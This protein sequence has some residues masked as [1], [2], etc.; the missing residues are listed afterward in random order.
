MT[1]IIEENFSCISM[2]KSE[3]SY[4]QNWLTVKNI[5]VEILDRGSLRQKDAYTPHDYRNHCVNI[6]NIISNIILKENFSGLNTEELFIL[7]VAVLL[8]DV[9]MALDPEKRGTHSADARD[10]VKREQRDHRLPFDREQAICIGDV[11]FG[12]SDLK[13]ENGI[14]TCKTI[15]ALPKKE[16]FYVGMSGK[17]INVRVLS[18]ILRLADELDINSRRIK[19]YKPD[20]YNINESSRPHWR[21]CEIFMFPKICPTDRSVI[22]LK[23]DHELIKED[24]NEEADVKLLLEVEQKINTELIYLNKN[25]FFTDCGLQGWSFHKVEIST[26]DDLSDRIDRERQKKKNDKI[27]EGVIDPLSSEVPVPKAIKREI[28]IDN[29]ALE[30]E[31]TGWVDTNKLLLSGHF[32]IEDGICARDWI[33]TQSLLEDP[34]YLRK[35]AKGFCDKL[36]DGCHV[37]GIGQQGSALASAMAL[38]K[39]VPFS[40]LI[41]DKFKK[42]QV[43]PDKAISF[44]DVS[45]LVL[46]TDVVVTGATISKAVDEIC[47]KL[48][49]PSD[50]VAAVFSVFVREPI[51]DR[52]E[53]FRAD[54]FT[55]LFA[56]NKSI[57]IELCQKP[58]CHR[59][60]FK[61]RGLKLYSNEPIEL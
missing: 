34:E 55:K 27:A 36:P 54:I 51:V 3:E 17:P 46:V 35:I 9:Y 2:L 20:D 61:E 48:K 10:F 31:I 21:K 60:I 8:H 33:D 4:F 44:I 49:L 28:I 32:I 23:P 47:R 56:L 42:F 53:G 6:Y 1:K 16:D 50:R 14:T 19:G 11:I 45:K 29:V 5:Y 30:N 7:D 43:D 39:R 58:S 57:P 15:E 18:S 37:V 13:T 52:T 26:V 59:C 22:H 40:Y 24:G 25:V 38:F 41:P 12:H